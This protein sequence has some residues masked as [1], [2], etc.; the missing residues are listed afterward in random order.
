MSDCA[1]AGQ[2]IGPL[3]SIARDRWNTLAEKWRP[4]M[5]RPRPSLAAT[6]KSYP[7]GL[8]TLARRGIDAASFGLAKP[9]A[10]KLAKIM[11]AKNCGCDARERW[12]NELVPNVATVGKMEWM[13]LAPKIL[14]LWKRL[15]TDQPAN[16]SNTP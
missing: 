3:T 12:L 8:G 14:T 4:R 6:C 15:R 16:G 2:Q 13:R 10:M 11:G 7:N 5:R 1:E 9:L